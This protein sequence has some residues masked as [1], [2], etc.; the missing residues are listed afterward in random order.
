M[1]SPQRMPPHEVLYAPADIRQQIAMP[2]VSRDGATVAFIGGIMSDFGSTGGDVY[3]LP[4]DGGSA[5][6]IT[7]G[8]ARIGERRSRGAATAACKRNCSPA[9]RRSWSDLGTG[10]QPA[11]AAHVLWSGEESLSNGDGY[12]AMACPSG[13]MAAEHESFTAPPEIEV[14]A[15]GSLAQFDRGQRGPALAARVQSIWW[16]SDGFDVQG[17]LLLPEQRTASCRW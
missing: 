14:G 16:K 17:W 2:R 1:P 7:P 3:T 9:T 13:V 8:D 10:R 12:A 15:V 4:L 6:N 5:T 11:A